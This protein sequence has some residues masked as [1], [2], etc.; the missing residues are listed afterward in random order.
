MCASQT[1][2]SAG[3]SWLGKAKTHLIVS[4][5]HMALNCGLWV[6][7]MLH[8]ACT[9]LGAMLFEIYKVAIGWP[10]VIGLLLCVLPRAWPL[11]LPGLLRPYAYF[12]VCNCYCAHHHAR[13][14]SVPVA[15]LVKLV[16]KAVKHENAHICRPGE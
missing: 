11:V 7:I 10:Y 2:P 14:Q 1:S 9:S 12:C 13:A 6:P 3:P 5:L 15:S 8:S 4:W 16:K